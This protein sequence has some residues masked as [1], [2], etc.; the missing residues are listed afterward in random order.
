M[1]AVRCALS[2]KLLAYTSEDHEAEKAETRHSASFFLSWW[3]PRPW[4]GAAHIQGT[5]SVNPFRSIINDIP[6]DVPH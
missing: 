3:D 4:D 1:M 6:K 2:R 5:S